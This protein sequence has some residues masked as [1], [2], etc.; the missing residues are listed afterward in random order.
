[1]ENLVT[2]DGELASRIQGQITS[3]QLGLTRTFE[4]F[5]GENSQFL[6]LLSRTESN[7]LPAAMLAT[8]NSVLHAE[9]AEILA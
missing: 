7:Q 3:V 2:G 1:V 8:V 9:K 6:A 4:R 5:V